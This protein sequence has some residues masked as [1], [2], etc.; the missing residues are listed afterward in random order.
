M[1]IVHD[2]LMAGIPELDAGG[3]IPRGRQGGMCYFGKGGGDAP[4]PDPMIG[5]AAVKNAQTGEQWLNFAREQ[6]K[7][8][9]ERQKQTD[10][11][12]TKVIN[13][14]LAT[15]DQTNQWAQEDRAR[16]KNVFQP[17]QD[18]FIQTAKTYDTPERQAQMAAEATA[19]V[20]KA[21]DTQRQVNTRSMAAMGINPASGRF[22]GVERATDLN[23]A[24]AGAGAA[25][26]ARQMVRD[27]A[28]ALK[29]D[30][31]NMGSGLP[32]STAAAYGI[33][34]NS[35]NSAVGNRSA[36]NSSFY[37]NQGV[38]GQG[39]GGAMQGYANEGNI[40]NNLYGNQL[41]AWQA[42]NQA[43]ATSAAGIGS[44]VG[45]IAGA[46]LSGFM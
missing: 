13:Q 12:T 39:F 29:A 45:T 15:Q 20:Q 27:K 11:L 3:F 7:V 5:I 2:M 40:L 25:N 42:N 9:N 1:K 36:A 8:G 43:N 17:M 33:G 41:Q 4:A 37:Q 35:G 31:I 44:M 21:A 6:F 10:A 18:E 23:T 22:A 38:M 30:A 32:S 46:G 19:D 24:I 14:Q 26:S 34:L 28:L 16:T